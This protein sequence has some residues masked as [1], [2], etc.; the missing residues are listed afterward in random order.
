MY[1]SLRRDSQKSAAEVEKALVDLRD[2]L[3]KRNPN[4]NEIPYN[5]LGFVVTDVIKEFI[6]S[7]ISVAVFRRIVARLNDRNI[8]AHLGSCKEFSMF[9]DSAKYKEVLV[10]DNCD[11]ILAQ[12]ITMYSELMFIHRNVIDGNSSS[13]LQ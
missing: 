10:F 1:S 5:V 7:P 4:P 8:P 3:A 9:G 6:G 11:F 13:P 12:K 2:K